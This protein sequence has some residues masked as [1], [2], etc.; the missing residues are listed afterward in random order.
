MNKNEKQFSYCKEM[1]EILSK[2][3][4]LSQ[5]QNGFTE[6]G[7]EIEFIPFFKFR[8]IDNYDVS[9]YIKIKQLVES[10]KGNL[11]W[12]LLSEEPFNPKRLHIIIPAKYA[13]FGIT[14]GTR[15]NA[16]V[17]PVEKQI[18]QDELF[19]KKVFYET[20][21]LANKDIPQLIIFLKKN[22]T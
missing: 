3:K 7:Y 15:K 10:F 1:Q 16:R 17:P 5:I 14:M 20:I 6:S 12:T 19:G 18:F 8:F 21:L 4:P 9:V 2:I 22:T 11:A 13:K